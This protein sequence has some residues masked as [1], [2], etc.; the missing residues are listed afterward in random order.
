MAWLM[1]TREDESRGPV[2]G[3]RDDQDLVVEDEAQR[4]R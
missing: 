4:R 2:Q 1:M 3:A